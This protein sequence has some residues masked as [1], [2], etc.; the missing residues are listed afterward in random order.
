MATDGTRMGG[1]SDPEWG[2]V[3]H[4]W[5]VGEV[6]PEALRQ[7][8][9]TALGAPAAPRVVHRVGAIP[10]LVTGKPDRRR[11]AASVRGPA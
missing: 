4:A 6:D 11:L 9:R 2:A 1:V 8:V 10:L 5:V 7:A 3:V